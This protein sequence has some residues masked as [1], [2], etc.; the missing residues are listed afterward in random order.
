MLYCLTA[1]LYN[2]ME[3]MFEHTS[4][5]YD[6]TNCKFIDFVPSNVRMCTTFTLVTEAIRH[7]LKTGNWQDSF[8]V[9]RNWISTV[10][11][12]QGNTTDMNFQYRDDDEGFWEYRFVALGYESFRYS[13]SSFS[14]QISV[15]GGVPHYTVDDGLQVG[16]Y[17]ITEI[18][19][20]NQY[21]KMAAVFPANPNMFAGTDVEYIIPYSIL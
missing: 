10:H 16:E 7:L 20:S 15:I 2:D 4:N 8:L 11:F 18:A 13:K 9:V 3:I 19:K 17:T 21:F 12:H 1:D 14:S 6:S 5:K